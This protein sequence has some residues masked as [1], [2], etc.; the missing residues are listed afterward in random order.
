MVYAESDT[1][2]EWVERYFRKGR[3][4]P[5]GFQMNKWLGKFWNRS[6]FHM[7]VIGDRKSL[8]GPFL[9]GLLGESSDGLFMSGILGRLCHGPV[10]VTSP[11][12][13][14]SPTRVDGVQVMA[15]LVPALSDAEGYKD[16]KYFRR[17]STCNLAIYCVDMSDTRLRGSV[18]R[19]LQELKP[20]WSRTIIVL[21]F[22]DAL[23]AL[24][25]QRDNP[26]FSK[27][28]YFNSKLA[29]WTEELRRM[30]GL[31][32]VQQEVVA[33]I[34]IYPVGG[35]PED[36][37]PNG[38]PWLPKL[39]LAIMEILSPKKKASFLRK[40]ATLL[41]TVTVPAKF[42]T[43]QSPTTPTAVDLMATMH[44]STTTEVHS[45]T[46]SNLPASA[47]SSVLSEDQSQSIRAALSKLR[48]EC[49]EFG[50]LVIGRTG[51][52]KSTL[53]NNL[54][55]KEVARVGHTLQSETPVVYP[56][57]D[58]VEGVPIVV[59]DTP[60]LGDVKGKED[61][62]KHL[63]MMKDFL[64]RKKIHLVVYCFQLNETIVT[65][66]L[67]GALRKYHEIGVD[68][69]HSVIALTFADALYVPK[70]EVTLSFF[71]DQQM[72]FWQRH[73]KLQLVGNGV[74]SDVVERLKICPTSLLPSDQL[75]NGQPWYVP[76]WL[77]IVEILTPAATV[78][79]LDIH[80]KNI[81]DEQAPPP[82]QCHK[83]DVNLSTEKSQNR[84]T[85]KFTAILEEAGMD[86]SKKAAILAAIWDTDAKIRTIYN[87]LHSPCDQSAMLPTQDTPGLSAG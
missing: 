71:F 29:E 9:S 32:G 52:G 47:V 18:L 41:R 2:T 5:Q 30:L 10:E 28:Q 31:I 61:E 87:L 27:G 36:L 12:A 42:V 49:P 39:S 68:W 84:L 43:P 81:S 86:S 23:P 57:E 11:G 20:D 74:N 73:L 53:I 8:S 14:S 70:G 44:V 19:T 25:R 76:F 58:L 26:A 48:K 78:R 64:T 67:I 56:Y 80:R 66:S 15:I 59:Y 55:G 37:L 63:E 22:P 72:D 79:F 17:V 33:T 16:E 40:Y 50:I 83:V 3:G 6:R 75:P 38:E 35:E 51:V 24:V 77:H 54:L 13:C 65:S 45:S 62:R 7:T 46:E 34:N 21:T 69:N 4:T 85:I 82:S 60:G 1:L